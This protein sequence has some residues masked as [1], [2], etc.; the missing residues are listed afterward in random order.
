MAKFE[1]NFIPLDTETGGLQAL[2]NPICE[3]SICPFTNDLE[4][5]PEYSNLI[6]PYNSSLQYT[7]GALQANGLSMSQIE[8]GIPAKQVIE[9]L[10]EYLTKLKKGKNLPVLICHNLKFD[11]SFLTEFF[12]FHKRDFLD[13]I[14]PEFSIDTMWFS[15]MRWLESVNFK[16]G[17]CVSNAGLEMEAQHR[18]LADTRATRDLAKYFIQ[19]MRSEA[20]GIKSERYRD[21]FEF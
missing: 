10:C 9:E 19:N 1:M 15:R 13:F 18:A 12:K 4:N 20:T 5:L 14:N 17:T 3:I 8:N 2:T 7:S 11:I 6:A 16:L 21:K